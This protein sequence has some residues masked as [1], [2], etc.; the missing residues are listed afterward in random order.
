LRK[1][2]KNPVGKNDLALRRKRGFADAK[3][4]TYNQF[5]RADEHSCSGNRVARALILVETRWLDPTY[6]HLYDF[7]LMSTL[8]PATELL[9][10]R[11]W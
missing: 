4:T 10:N 8:T 3:S 11:F 2:K 5:E 9:A 6:F 1:L 7:V